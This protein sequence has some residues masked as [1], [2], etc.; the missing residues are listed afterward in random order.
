[1]AGDHLPIQ[2]AEI[3]A[4]LDLYRIT[5]DIAFF[6]D[7]ITKTDVEYLKYLNDKK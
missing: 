1:M 3:K 5:K 6:I 7:V 4:Y 2:L